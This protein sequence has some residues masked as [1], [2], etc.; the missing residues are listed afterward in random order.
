MGLGLP[1]IADGSYFNVT[2]IRVGVVFMRTSLKESRQRIVF[3]I[4]VQVHYDNPDSVMDTVSGRETVRAI[5]VILDPKV[6]A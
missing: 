6:G 4:R 3:D 5:T 1:H 2:K